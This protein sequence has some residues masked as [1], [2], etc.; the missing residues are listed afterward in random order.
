MTVSHHPLCFVL[1]TPSLHGD[2]EIGDNRQY[3][4]MRSFTR[5]RVRMPFSSSLS[6]ICVLRLWIC[7]ASADPKRNTQNGLFLSS[8][9]SRPCDD[10]RN[11]NSIIVNK[12]DLSREITLEAIK[13]GATS[14]AR[15][16]LSHTP[17]VDRRTDVLAL[18]AMVSVFAGRRYCHGQSSGQLSS[19]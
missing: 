12:R 4:K 17:A 2:V 15:W 16:G 6:P 9:K 5:D 8:A 3:L 13:S 14:V 19:Q 1:A 18:L 11:I 7:A 10:L